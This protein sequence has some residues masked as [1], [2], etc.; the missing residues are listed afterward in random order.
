M[1]NTR[2]IVLPE[3]G[4]LISDEVSEGEPINDAEAFVIASAR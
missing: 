1:G 2:T 3:T 4:K